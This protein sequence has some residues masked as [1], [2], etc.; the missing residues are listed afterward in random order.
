MPHKILLFRNFICLFA[1]PLFGIA[2]HINAREEP[3]T[4]TKEPAWDDTSSDKWKGFQEVEIPSTADGQLQSAYFL[5]A[6][7]KAP[8]LISL[9]T[10][11]GDYSQRD[12]IAP[13]AQD[14]G[15]NYIHPNF[16]GMNNTP[17]STLSSKALADIED[18]IQYAIDHGN[19]DMD[20]IFIVG[21]SGGGYATLGAYMHTKHPV[22]AYM[23]WVPISDIEAWY[24]QSLVRNKKYA[25]HILKSTSKGGELN[26]E[27]ARSRSPLYFAMPKVSKGKLEIHAGINDGYTGSVPTSQSILFFN[28]LAREYGHEDAVVSEADIIKILSRGLKPDPALGTLGDRTILF[29]RETPEVSLTIFDGGHEMLPEYCFERITVLAKQVD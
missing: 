13:I 23:A 9:H 8:L 20:N 25:R 21:T 28:R 10:W 3:G 15:W 5:P 24:Y 29:Q 19:V 14:A 26:V 22:K 1:I 6:E 7:S 2:G 4:K 12:P 18:A 11:S 16:R 17:D 27:E